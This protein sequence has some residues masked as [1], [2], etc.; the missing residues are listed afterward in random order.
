MTIQLREAATAQ[1]R[2]SSWRQ[3]GVCAQVGGDL[4]FPEKGGT[5]R[6]VKRLCQGCDV[7]D[8]CLEWALAH[9]ERFGVWGGLSE[10]ERRALKKQQAKQA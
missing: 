8:E 7:Q 10:R 6:E 9:D 4:F 3:R 1:T 2:D 5:T